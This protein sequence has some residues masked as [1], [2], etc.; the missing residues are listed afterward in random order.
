MLC[1][2]GHAQKIT[3]EQQAIK[4]VQKYFRTDCKTGVAYSWTRDGNIADRSVGSYQI[5]EIKGL[6]WKLKAAELSTVEKNNGYTFRGTITLNAA[7][8]RSF[9]VYGQNVPLDRR[10]SKGW[11]EWK[12]FPQ[13]D[14]TIIIE[15]KN[16]VWK[17]LDVAHQYAVQI[18]AHDVPKCTNITNPPQ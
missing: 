2:T 13:N 9:T 12:E 16:G 10:H 8:F 14:Y 18:S 1:R 4:V 17:D 6:T 5:Y 15:K 3:P 7:S 11:G